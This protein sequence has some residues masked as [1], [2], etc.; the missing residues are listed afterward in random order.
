MVCLF[1]PYLLP[2]HV[3]GG[4]FHGKLLREEPAGARRGCWD[5]GR[6]PLHAVKHNRLQAL[7]KLCVPQPSGA[8]IAASKAGSQT[9]SRRMRLCSKC[10][11]GAVESALENQK[12]SFPPAMPLLHPLLTKLNIAP[13]GKNFKDPDRFLGLSIEGKTVLR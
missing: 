2:L 7:E 4:Q 6:W 10:L 3:Q 8:R 11:L 13:A 1:L 5:S 9:W 12:N